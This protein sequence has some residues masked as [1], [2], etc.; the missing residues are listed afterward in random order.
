[1]DTAF[2]HLAETVIATADFLDASTRLTE[3]EMRAP[4][5]L[6]GWTRAHVVA[7]L[8]RNADALTA[9]LRGAQEGEVR[10]MYDS[11]EQRDADI[12]AAAAR[13]PAEL[14][15]DA[16]AAA[17]RWRV[18]A[19]GVDLAHL[20]ALGCRTPGAETWPVRRVGMMRRT[21]VEVHHADLGIG[22][23]AGDWPADLVEALM[24][25]RHREL[26]AKGVTVRWRATD[27]RAVWETGDPGEGPE[28]SGPAADVIWW[29]LGRGSGAGL[30]C[31][32]PQLPELGRWT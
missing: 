11:Q 20:D 18:A 30:T 22:Y 13:P 16:A 7:H 28:V 24:K 15:E 4:S 27:T 1:M 32:E 17:D 5:V 10:W 2:P 29:L 23:T 21:E 9:V 3:T 26:A 8:A 6:P 25:R 14:V 31:S 12:E 19:S